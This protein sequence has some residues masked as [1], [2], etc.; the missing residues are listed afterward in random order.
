[1]LSIKIIKTKIL[2]EQ[3]EINPEKKINIF[4]GLPPFVQED[5]LGII[6]IDRKFTN[7]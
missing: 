5:F 4:Q 7:N 2:L 6:F 3:G 1:M